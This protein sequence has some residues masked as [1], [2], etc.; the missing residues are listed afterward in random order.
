MSTLITTIA[1]ELD[2]PSEFVTGGLALLDRFHHG[3]ALDPADIV[4]LGLA[5]HVVYVRD[6]AWCAITRENAAVRADSWTGVAAAL[7]PTFSAPAISL[8]AL[9]AFLAGD[10]DRGHMLLGTALANQPDYFIAEQ[11]RTIVLF[12]LRLDTNN[13][14]LPDPQPT[15]E[16]VRPLAW[17]ITVHYLAGA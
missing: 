10:A 3:L 12:G 5:L 14:E 2:D 15:A 9:A 1:Q 16:W 13:V 11:L 8:A 4:R 6:T 7:P 17:R